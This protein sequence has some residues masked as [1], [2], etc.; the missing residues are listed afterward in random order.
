[1]TEIQLDVPVEMRDGTVLRADVYSPAGTGPWPVLL[2]R[3]PYGK[4]SAL[5]IGL[6]D[7]LAAAR[8]GFM[9]VIQ[10]TRGRFA[11]EGEWEPFTHEE[12]DGYD[13][14]RWAASLPGSNGSVG[15]IGGSY[16]GNTQWMAALAKPPELKA[17][18]PM[19][20]WCDPEDGLWT[21]GG[22]IELGVGV[23]WSFMMGADVLMRRHATDLEGLVSSVS[24]LVQDLDG[25]G[26]DGYAE[27]PAGQF[28]A[29]ARHDLPELGYERSRREPEWAQSCTV[30]GR[31]DEVDLPSF[32]VGGW[33]D[34]FSQGTLDNFTAMRRA[35]RSATLV[36]GPWTHTNFR[37]MVGDVDFGFAANSDFMGMRGRLQDMLFDWFR[38]TLGEGEPLEPDTGNVLLFVMG[39]NQWREET[40]W[41]LSR[42]VD[43]EFHLREGGRLT[44][45]PPSTSEQQP[46]EFTYDPMDPVPT[47]GGAGLLADAFRP[48]PLDQAA[49]EAR[50]DVLVFTTEP[51]TEDVEV[52]GRVR[53][54]LFA[55]TDAPSTDWVARLCDVDEHGV[56]RNVTDGIVRVREASQ[57][58]PAEHVV[59]MWSTSIVFR[60]GHRIRVQVTSSNF[61]RWDRNLNTGEPEESATTARVARQQV[62]Y[63]STR[64]SRIVLPVVPA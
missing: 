40:E 38:R 54:V 10:D 53:A 20:T 17:I 57:G 12:S 14:V 18:A 7:P 33:F 6:L 61:P 48:G 60:A 29:F 25:L 3:L 30:A 49:V 1:M 26:R 15:T 63:D 24:S 34:V 5:V 11:S 8:R 62:F 19:I 23:S 21:R 43:T 56:S 28:P 2:S 52:T 22:A 51:L 13:T 42:A 47:V 37:N 36:V 46:E 44:L 59:D 27:L 31:H 64:P 41:P 9:V 55:A 4:Q 39:V 16:F 50:K 35:G 45:E 32:Q 58:E